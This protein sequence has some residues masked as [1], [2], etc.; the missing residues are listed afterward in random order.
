MY[1]IQRVEVS[2]RDLI[3]CPTDITPP[4]PPIVV[5]RDIRVDVGAAFLAADDARGAEVDD[6]DGFVACLCVGV[7]G[8]V[9]YW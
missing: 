6:V 9:F 7:G 2:R 8:W 1:L 3:D 5:P 4:P